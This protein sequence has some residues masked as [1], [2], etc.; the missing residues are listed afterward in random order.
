MR[1]LEQALEQERNSVKHLKT[2]LE[3]ERDRN[4]QCKKKDSQELEVCLCP[5]NALYVVK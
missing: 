2:M 1:A 3:G 5:E 4:K